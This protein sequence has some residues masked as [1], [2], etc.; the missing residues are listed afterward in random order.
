V[1]L[2]TRTPGVSW[3]PPIAAVL[4]LA[5]LT[6][7]TY[8]GVLTGGVLLP[9]DWL[10][11]A[12]Y[13][14][15]ALD[16]GVVSV[17]PRQNDAIAQLHPLDRFTRE[18]LK[19]GSVP[20]WNPYLG[21]GVPHLATGFT[22][23]LYPP[24]WLTLP[25]DAESGRNAE[26]LLHIVMAGAFQFLYLRFMGCR[27]AAALLGALAFAWSGALTLRL[28]LNYIFDTLVWVPAVLLGVERVLQNRERAVPVLALAAGMQV[29]AGSL[30][31]LLASWML[32]GTYVAVRLLQKPRPAPR[33]LFLLILGV[34]LAGGLAA[35]QLAPQLELVALSQRG[36]RTY[37]ELRG[38]GASWHT[39]LTL[40]SPFVAGAEFSRFPLLGATVRVAPLYVG[41]VSLVLI[42]AAVRTGGRAGLALAVAGGCVAAVAA[43]TPALQALYLAFPPLGGLRYVHTFAHVCTVALAAAVGW[44]AE[45]WL[46]EMD[47]EQAHASARRLAVAAAGTS[48]LAGTLAIIAATG[49]EPAVAGVSQQCSRAAALMA[50]TLILLLARRR[51]WISVR[52][53]S[54]CLIL[55]SSAELTRM[56]A[57]F[58]PV[59]SPRRHPVLPWTSALRLVSGDPVHA[60]AIGVQPKDAGRFG[61]WVVGSNL[62]QAFGIAGAGAYHSL[63]PARLVRYHDVMAR[64]AEGA[65]AVEAL[66]RRRSSLVS[67]EHYDFRATALARLMGIRYLFYRPS[68]R[69]T[70]RQGL[71]QVYDGVVD[72][73][74]FTGHLP[75]AFVVSAF[76][77]EPDPERLLARLAAPDFK[78]RQTVLLEAPPTSGRASGSRDR[79]SVHVT[80]SE[81]ERS[82]YDVDSVGG[83]L[84]VVTDTLYPGW[85]ARVNGAPVPIL[86]ADYLFRAVPVPA[87]RS[88]VEMSYEPRSFRIGALV[89][90]WS[91]AIV[92]LLMR[93]S[94]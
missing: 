24:F 74:R 63:L 12:Y 45:A 13:P 61:P 64:L 68:D 9:S 81:P 84:L 70:R 88:S 55:L 49:T 86:R 58:N 83:G 57:A 48:V 65:T 59:V 23:A 50:G 25:F 5:G 14:W 47:G 41:A 54:A 16:P 56:A 67:L 31:D 34:L 62:F 44:G 15:H 92:L 78:P 79:S 75:R 1:P 27:W 40:L 46:S 76:E 94:P 52:A 17:N 10:Y 26:I 35:A 7:A 71:E 29:L 91:A 87:G 51:G 37:E 85:Q 4:V 33:V 69:P 60:R 18:Q 42:P 43:G 80:A 38:S 19:E 28:P 36:R 53:L 11:E 2:V 21:A 20:L 72:V 22:R 8:P 82:A 93:R 32:V 39:L 6:L 66:A 30:P 89:S 77:V 73:Y 90:L 3:A